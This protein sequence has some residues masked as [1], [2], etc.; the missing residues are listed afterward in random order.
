MNRCEEVL[1]HHGILGMKWG[2]R[3]YQNKDGS[4]TDAGRRHYGVSEKMDTD[5]K[6]D[7][8]KTVKKIESNTKKSASKY[9][10]ENEKQKEYYDKFIKKGLSEEMAK[11]MAYD[12]YKTRTMLKAAAITTVAAAGAYGLYK[13]KKYV[14][15]ILIDKNTL[16]G[17]VTS[18]AASEIDSNNRL[19]HNIYAAFENADKRR[20]YHIH[21]TEMS[22][23]LNLKP[24][25]SFKIAGHKTGRKLMNEL[26]SSDP[27]AKAKA[28]ELA[29]KL[30]SNAIFE[31]QAK[32]GAEASRLLKAGKS[33]NKKAYEGL[34]LVMTDRSESANEFGKLLANHASA[35]GFFGLKDINDQKYSTLISKTPVMLFKDAP[36]K[37]VRIKDIDTTTDY[38]IKNQT[39]E[40]VKLKLHNIARE[41]KKLPANYV[42]GAAVVGLKSSKQDRRTNKITEFRKNNPNTKKTDEE[43]LAYLGYKK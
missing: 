15:D 11:A 16:I 33:L 22:Q 38:F 19:V 7:S 2:V 35:K 10:P 36:I 29:D 37:S 32:A 1:A 18:D 26:I 23:W 13:H 28:I 40:S 24:T 42:F 30:A 31:T 41:E 3:R 39:A 27:N 6:G 8:A 17:R 14:S 5:T 4:L 20:Y 9:N 34:N 25:E 43:I 21:S 12:K